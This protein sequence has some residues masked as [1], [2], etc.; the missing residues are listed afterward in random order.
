[1]NVFNEQS[2]TRMIIGVELDLLM[3]PATS[4]LEIPLV[5]GHEIQVLKSNE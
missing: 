4:C 3:K 1:M 5:D 2:N